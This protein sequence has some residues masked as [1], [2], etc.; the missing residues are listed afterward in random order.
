MSP[1]AAHFVPA[2]SPLRWNDFP[3]QGGANGT[4]QINAGGEEGVRYGAFIYH[5]CQQG[6]G[7]SVHGTIGIDP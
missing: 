4:A 3:A 7:H 1:P 6:V 2:R 5:A